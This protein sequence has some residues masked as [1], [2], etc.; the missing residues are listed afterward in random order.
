MCVY[1]PHLTVTKRGRGASL[2][3]P[4]CTAA[5]PSPYLSPLFPSPSSPPP[6]HCCSCK[7][8]PPAADSAPTQSSVVLAALA[9]G[10]PCPSLLPVSPW[11]FAHQP[12]PRADFRVART[13][14]EPKAPSQGHAP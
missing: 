3:R 9:A 13:A 8:N 7:G 5:A 4:L 14:S 2:F 6:R 12:H 11:D 10:L 1:G